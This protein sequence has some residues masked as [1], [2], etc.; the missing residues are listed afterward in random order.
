MKIR[1]FSIVIIIILV[2]CCLKQKIT[3]LQTIPSR[4]HQ[5]ALVI[6]GGP[7][8]NISNIPYSK[9]DRIVSMKCY[10]CRVRGTADIMVYYGGEV[11]DNKLLEKYK[12]PKYCK[13]MDIKKCDPNEIWLVDKTRTKNVIL[14]SIVDPIHRITNFHNISGDINHIQ[15]V[16][17][18]AKIYSFDNKKLNDIANQHGLVYNDTNILLTAIRYYYPVMTTGLTTILQAIETFKTPIYISG[19]D[20]L[21]NDVVVD[22]ASGRKPSCTHDFH[23]EHQVLKLLINQNLVV[24]LDFNTDHEN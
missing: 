1:L 10:N 8:V 16:T 2:L 24:V 9:F 13:L 15:D 5:T 23:L 6:G 3:Y 7:S 21:V 11:Y 4:K 18:R 19:F 17:K 22:N 14:D 12:D 20:N